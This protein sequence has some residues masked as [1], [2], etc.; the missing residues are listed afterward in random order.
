MFGSALNPA[1]PVVTIISAMIAPAI[2]ILA[3]GNLLN[4]VLQRLTRVV[5]RA[6]FVIDRVKELE[7]AGKIE[8][9]DFLRA[10]L[11]IYRKRESM[12][13]T[14]ILV[15]YAALACFSLSSLSVA[16]VVIL[17]DQWAM[18]PT[19]FAIVGVLLLFGGSSVLFQET[20]LATGILDREI[21]RALTKS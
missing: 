10:E 2:F 19:V 4:S 3:V 17:H 14:T 21:E 20:R 12:I 7:A 18:I 5:D 16:V 1:L 13:Y 6:R 9:A 15:Y 8:E 11:V